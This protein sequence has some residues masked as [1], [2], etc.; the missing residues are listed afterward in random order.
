MEFLIVVGVLW[1]IGCAFYTQRVADSKGFSTGAAWWTGGLFFG[2][3]ALLAAGLI[4]PSDR[5]RERKV[6]ASVRPR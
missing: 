1:L 5:D 2:P 4:E 3:I 6:A